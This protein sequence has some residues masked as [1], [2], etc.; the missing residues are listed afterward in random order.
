MYFHSTLLGMLFGVCSVLVAQGLL[1]KKGISIPWTIGYLLVVLPFLTGG[2]YTYMAAITS[3]FLL[4]GLFNIVRVKHQLNFSFN[5]TTFTLG[6]ITIGY[7]ITP[8]WAADKGMSVFGIL[9]YVPVLLLAFLLMQYRNEQK[10][11]FLLLLPVS[12]AIMTVAGCMLWVIPVTKDFVV[13][14]GRL[15]SFLQYP[16]TFAAFLLTGL[17]VLGVKPKKKW[18]DWLIGLILIFGIFRS[19]SRT[20][21]LLLV[22]LVLAIAVHHKKIPPFIPLILTAA[23][24]ISVSILIMNGKQITFFG[25]DFGSLFIRILYYKD[26]LPVILRHPFGLGYTG[27]RALET[28]FQ[29]SRYTV[30][31][32]HSGL[33]QMLLDI[34]WIPA[35]FFTITVIRTLCSFRGKAENKMVLLVLSAHALVDFDLQFFLFWAILLLCLDFEEGKVFTLKLSR[36]C[37]IAV[38][39]PLLII[40]IWLGLG[41]WFYQTGNYEKTLE[42]MPFHTDALAAE[43]MHTTDPEDMDQLADKILLQNPTHALAYSA[44]ANA[45]FSRGQI[46]EMIQYKEKAISLTPYTTQEYCDYIEKLYMVLEL[47]V[48]NGDLDSAVYCLEKL[49]VVPEMMD[50]VSAKTDPLAHKTGNSTELVLPEPYQKLLA[51]LRIANPTQ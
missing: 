38:A 18:T 26:A 42:L 46:L 30:S 50:A 21:I 12:G 32:V 4:M 14:N 24:I 8:L 13:V 41:D 1:H 29:T 45:A 20:G 17:A 2:F 39:I 36:F 10:S 47:Y 15:S 25:R 5:L 44:K 19:G 9:R 22:L 16:N 3:M 48:Q 43:L 31:F 49:L 28:T 37:Y 34:G 6:I 35:L 33:L 23:A 40:C 7:C 27:Y 51:E 11:H